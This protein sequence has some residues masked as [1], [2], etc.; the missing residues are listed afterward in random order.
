MVHCVVIAGHNFSRHWARSGKPTA[1]SCCTFDRKGEASA[2]STS[3]R[4]TRCKTYA[5]QDQGLDTV[6]AHE[7]LGFAADLR[8]FDVAAHTLRR[9]GI[10]QVGLL[11]NNPGKVRA[12]GAAGI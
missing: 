7:Y 2:W 1:G 5:L 4:H 3:S 6:Q 9:L 10:E 12:L 8:D 11:T